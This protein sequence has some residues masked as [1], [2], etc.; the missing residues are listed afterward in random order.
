MCLCEYCHNYIKDKEH[1]LHDVQYFSGYGTVNN[2]NT[3][4]NLCKTI[5]GGNVNLT[6]FF[7][8]DNEQVYLCNEHYNY[9]KEERNN[10]YSYFKNSY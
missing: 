4:C 3:T 1:I 2:I 9:R 5:D 6:K 8:K 7:K 10:N